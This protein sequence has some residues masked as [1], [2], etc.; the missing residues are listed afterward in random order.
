[1]NIMFLLCILSCFCNIQTHECFFIERANLHS[2]L[3]QIISTVN[4][5]YQRQP[6]NRTDFPRIT[7][8]ALIAL[9]Q[10]EENQLFIAVSEN[11]EICGTILLHESEISLLS[12]HPRCQGQGLGLFLLHSAEQE[13]F[14]NYNT[15]FLKVIPLFQENLI[16]FYESAGYKSF[17]EYEPLSQEK[18]DRI[19]ERYHSEVFALIMR[20]ENPSPPP[21]TAAQGKN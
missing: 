16:R 12:V 2:N 6:F 14:K 9:L 17:G 11:N 4:L 5:A 1:M 19:Q 21:E 15:V 8:P 7:L 18:L 10:N 20:K 3:D 13:A